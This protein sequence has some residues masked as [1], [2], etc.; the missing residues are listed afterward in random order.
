LV[1]GFLADLDPVVAVET[2]RRLA[3]VAA[4]RTVPVPGRGPGGAMS[5][6]RGSL[7]HPFARIR[8][9]SIREAGPILAV[10]RRVL[11][12]SAD[13]RPA[14]V[15]LTDRTGAPL[16]TVPHG[17]EVEILAWQPFG[18]GGTRYRVLSRK[19]GVEGWVGAANVK[20]RPASPAAARP[21]AA[22]TRTEPAPPAR[23]P[24]LEARAAPSKAAP[25]ARKKRKR[26]PARS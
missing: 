26:A 17:G 4:A 6:P 22:T 9:S 5:S 23:K 7:S 19:K 13:G 18:A 16:A 21:A 11:V 14:P 15:T 1:A 24:P 2:A 20:P 10:G 8:P 12:V 3:D 25:P